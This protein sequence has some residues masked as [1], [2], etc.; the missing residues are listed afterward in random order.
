MSN[1]I[2][3]I[4]QAFMVGKITARAA[5]SAL[6]GHFQ[7]PSSEKRQVMTRQYI[8]EIMADL[9]AGLILIDAASEGLEESASAS[10]T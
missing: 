5:N 10:R 6:L 9:E 1:S 7:A 8:A 3:E 4:L 2:P